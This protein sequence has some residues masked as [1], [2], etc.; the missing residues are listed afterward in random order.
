MAFRR[1]RVHDALALD[2]QY[3]PSSPLIART[4]AVE[5]VSPWASDRFCGD[6]RVLVS[7]LVTNAVLHGLP[8]IRLNV[9]TVAALRVRFEVFDG[10]DAL[11]EI[12]KP[13]IESRSGRG[14]K[15]VDAIATDWGARRLLDGKVVWCELTDPA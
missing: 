4:R 3:A 1:R 14:L 2:L 10:S 7:E 5:F 11:P 12:R 6:L 15:I 8:D 9:C 13:S